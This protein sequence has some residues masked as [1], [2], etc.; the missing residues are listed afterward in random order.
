M[1]RIVRMEGALSDY[2]TMEEPRK[3]APAEVAPAAPATAELPPHSFQV[4]V[5]R[6]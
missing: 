6:K 3:I 2:N 1:I 4:L 5:F